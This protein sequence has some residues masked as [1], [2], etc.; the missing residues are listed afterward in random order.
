MSQSA[1]FQ[2]VYDKINPPVVGSREY[3]NEND[4]ESNHLLADQFL[5]EI[6]ELTAMSETEAGVRWASLDHQPKVQGY[7]LENFISYISYTREAAMDSWQHRDIRNRNQNHTF[8]ENLHNRAT[9]QFCVQALI[10]DKKVSECASHRSLELKPIFVVTDLEGEMIEDKIA[11]LTWNYSGPNPATFE[12]SYDLDKTYRMHNGTIRVL[13]YTVP[14]KNTRDLH[15]EVT[16]LRYY[17]NYTFKVSVNYNN[18]VYLPQ[19]KFLATGIELPPN[20][21]PPKIVDVSRKDVKLKLN[22]AADENGPVQL[23]WLIVAPSNYSK[24]FTDNIDNVELQSEND[25]LYIA[26]EFSQNELWSF[27]HQT[28]SIGDGKTY[29][30]RFG[31]TYFNRPLSYGRRYKAFLRAFIGRPGGR[32]DKV[33]EAV[34]KNTQ[35]LITACKFHCDVR[36][37]TFI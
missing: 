6:L 23:Y 11:R 3:L 25:N 4:Y 24:N 14:Y 2:N 31:G 15:V 33:G 1:H 7:R 9:Y 37:F 28:L 21:E 5:I 13:H 16:G 20:F 36:I 12:I 32:N 22:A 26:A 10:D 34:Q 27:P 17:I 30:G 35:L 18:R 29:N 19:R 8:I